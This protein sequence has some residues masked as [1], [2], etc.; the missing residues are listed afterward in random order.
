MSLTLINSPGLS[1]SNAYSSLATAG[2][3]IEENIHITDTWSTL[4]TTS[5]TSCVIYSTSILDESMEWLGSRGSKTQSLDWPRDAVY[6]EDGYAVSTTTIPTFLQRACAF[7]AYD[8]SQENRIKENDTLGF[9]R[10]DA[11][12]LRM[13]IDKYD[14]KQVIPDT[15]WDMI[16]FY[17]T[18]VSSMSRTLV[19]K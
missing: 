15:I 4:A 14:R 10:L 5:K 12:S 2:L 8:L 6:D 17:G 16:K 9:K 3:F 11:G 13:D 7:L 1:T 19:R 18:K